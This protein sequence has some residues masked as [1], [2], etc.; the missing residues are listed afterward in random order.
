MKL[1]IYGTDIDTEYKVKSIHKLFHEDKN[2]IDVSIDIEDVDNVLRIEATDYVE[3][4][5]II[6]KV[7]KKG[8]Y[9]VEL[10]D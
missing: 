4:N 3:E 9:C 7:E 6:N 10:V 5:D 8:F 2:I 1:F